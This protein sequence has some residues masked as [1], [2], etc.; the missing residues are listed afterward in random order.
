MKDVGTLLSGGEFRAALAPAARRLHAL[1]VRPR[2]LTFLAEVVR[3]GGVPYAAALPEPMP[4][5]AQSEPVSAWLAAA[6]AQDDIR[7]ARWL[8]GVAVLLLSQP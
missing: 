5:P 7:V 4:L 8:D 1:G 2:S 6:T 3:R